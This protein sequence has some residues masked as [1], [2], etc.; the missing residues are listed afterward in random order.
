MTTSD[1]IR[2]LEKFEYGGLHTSTPRTLS[3]T[4]PDGTYYS[5]VEIVQTSSG[6]GCAGPELGLKIISRGLK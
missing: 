3:I 6:D 2:L 1:L 4:T 5:D